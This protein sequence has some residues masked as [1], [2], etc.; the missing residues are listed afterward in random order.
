MNVATAVGETLVRCGVGAV[1]G[2]VGSG[3]FEVTNAMIASGARYVA[4]RHECGAATMADAYARMTGG[5]A[6]VSVHQGCGLTNAMTGITEAAKSRTPVVVIAAEATRPS[7]NFYVDQ[8]ALAAAVGAV[9]MRV[10]SADEAVQQ[11]AAA[12]ATA[13]GERR[14]VLLNLPLDV[15][16]QEAGPAAPARPPAGPPPVPVDAGELDRL[17]AALRTA[18]RP[19]FVAGR[20]ARGPGSREALERLADRSGALLATSAV[21]RGLFTGN[22]WAL[23]V[24]GGFATPLAAEL[25]TG[26]DLVVGWGC[27]L[28]MWTMRHGRLIADDAVVVQVDVD[29]DA[30]GAQRALAFGVVGDVRR[31]A[32]AAAAALPGEG[33]GY[34]SEEVRRA[35]AERGRW[36]DV[37]FDEV[38]EPGRIDARTLTTA[39]DDL[40]P[41]D[42]IVSV[43]S[44]NF[45]GYPSMFLGV[46]DEF[47]FCFTQAFQ[48]VG[49]GLA[50]A[51][52][53]A[54][55]R[56]DRLPVAA[57]GDG[58]ALMGAA[59][60]ETVARLGLPMVVV[61]YDD[62]AYGA[63]VHHFGPSGAPLDTVRFPETDLAAVARGFGFEAVT[64]RAREDLDAVA[65][66]VGGPR[67]APLL[68]DAKV[69]RSA[70]SWWLEEA[71]RGH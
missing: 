45:M 19:V 1:F 12:V 11:A 44:G 49:L 34:R 53:A 4:A 33:G 51:I 54:V 26:A 23:D 37:P 41:A 21:A 61:V 40:L 65:S 48:S 2:V 8:P 3:N 32:E 55:A 17:A 47:G 46:P 6:A 9:S 30:L 52:G 22:P 29:A 10:A 28:N 66:W 15:Q 60:L 68:I 14:V 69:Q 18:R 70:P 43:D 64:V 39:L 67:T 13:V 58:G 20:G 59:E 31:V 16:P 56:P 62:E 63:E 7:S 57:L 71:F 36:R 50:T 42:R 24:S 25:I 35:I 27:T 38:A 5:V